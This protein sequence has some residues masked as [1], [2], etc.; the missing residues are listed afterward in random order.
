MAAKRKK[1]SLL[2]AAATISGSYGEQLFDG[3]VTHRTRTVPASPVLRVAGRILELL[4][5]AAAVV[6]VL[7]FI[8]RG[9]RTEGVE[10]HP[11]LRAHAAFVRDLWREGCRPDRAGGGVQID[12]ALAIRKLDP[13]YGRETLLQKSVALLIATP[14]DARFPP[15][16]DTLAMEIVRQLGTRVT[17]MELTAARASLPTLPLAADTGLTQVYPRRSRAERC[18]WLVEMLARRLYPNR[19]LPARPIAPLR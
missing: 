16:V 11:S 4:L 15:G 18:D 5:A 17:I 10:V 2:R 12:P 1:G 6:V 3:R 19:G 7:W 8:H 14:D 13:I 9:L